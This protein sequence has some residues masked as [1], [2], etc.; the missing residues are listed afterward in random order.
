MRSTMKRLEPRP[1]ALA[2]AALFLAVLLALMLF[3]SGTSGDA[4]APP[5][6]PPS[7]VAVAAIATP[8]PE[9]L[10]PPPSAEGLR[11]Y[12]LLGLGAIIGFPDGR[13]SFIA[14]GRDVRPGLRVARIEQQTVILASAGGEIRLGFD[15]AAAPVATAP[16]SPVA[17]AEER[18]RDET[19]VYRF[20]LEP[21]R[22]SGR[23]GAF[24][25]RPGVSMPALDRAGIRPGDV[26]LRVNGSQ[27]DEERMLELAW[28]I[29]NST[30][31]EF[32]IE[33]GGRRMRLAIGGQTS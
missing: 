11:L 12:G 3:R 17:A 21:R 24:A 10:P 23:I 32:E 1:L 8:A 31:T 7:P 16:A 6:A 13:Q 15:G 22:I 18:Q 30:R 26:I 5:P 20:G 4:A 28:T 33:R 19:L 2:S 27:F 9:P 29:A 25:V 14:V